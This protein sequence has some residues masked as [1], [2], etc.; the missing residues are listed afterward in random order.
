VP[1]SLP[2]GTLVRLAIP[3]R[4]DGDQPLVITGLKPG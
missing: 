3:I 4:N 1:G 2:L